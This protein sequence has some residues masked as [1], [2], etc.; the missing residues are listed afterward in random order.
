MKSKLW[1]S[2]SASTLLYAGAAH[3]QSAS[4]PQDEKTA[5]GTVTEV[6]V[7]AE[8]RTVNLQTAAVAASVLSGAELAKKGV[9]SVDQL[10][11][12]MPSVTIQNFGQGNDF[13]IRGIGK[14][15]T[16]SATL[17]GVVTYRDGVATFPGYFQEEPYYDISA[18]EVLRGPQGT[19]AGQNATGGAVF[20]TEKNPVIDGG[21]HGYLQGQYG[22]YNDV[23]VQGAINL[24]IND[25]LAARVAFNDEYRD[26][27]YHVT[28]NYTGH[29][30]ELKESNLRFSLLW[31]PIDALKVLFK[32]DYNYIDQGGFPADPF[33]ATNNPFKITSN[34]EWLAVDQFVRS[35]LDV[36]YKLADGITLRSVTGYQRG[37]SAMKTDL[38][39]TSALPF[40]LTDGD[41]EELW[42]EE[43]N[44]ISPD[45]GPLTWIAGLYYSYD[46]FTFPNPE[47]FDIGEPPRVFDITIAGTNPKET[48]AV[49]GQVSYK[50]ASG[51]E[52]QVGARYSDFSTSNHLVTTI[53]ELGLAVPQNQ[54]EHDSKL[55]GKVALNWTINPNNFV[56]AFVATGH[57]GGGLNASTSL[58]L[59]PTFKPEDVTDYE[60]G[61][62]ATALDGHLKTQLG[63]YYNDYK[64][65]QVSIGDPNNATQSLE[66][67][68]TT[69]SKIYGFEG[70]AQ[71]VFGAL[72]FD[73]GVSVLHSELGTFFAVDPRLPGTGVCSPSRGPVSAVCQNITGNQQDYAPT[74]TLN[75]GAEYEFQLED[76]ATLTP[77]VNFGHIAAQ[78]AT[79]FED[80]AL[81]DRL[82]ERNLLS[83]QLAYQRGDW[84]VIVYG[85]NLTDQTYVSALNAGL[86]YVGPPRQYGLRLSKAF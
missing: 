28:G 15:A 50:L 8:R 2:I 54:S 32:T 80:P 41:N 14:G 67:N 1:L 64:N 31:Q 27:F 52:L 17:V 72:S 26:S 29:P 55:T 3:A 60:V 42:S 68:I 37:R 46:Q 33:N 53:P 19:F 82:G 10:Q 24:P 49:F 7:T 58:V 83:G 16:N 79:L 9:V 40:T 57:K 4:G 36:N 30:G 6:V 61:W 13:N 73:L 21:Y 56:Y 43:V 48:K 77:R 20:I 66:L 70:Q 62:K 12:A 74:F 75:V 84:R 76:G 59:P 86:R 38:D 18:L 45:V 11:T 63:G 44:V 78:W 25:T 23:N 71:A 35:V 47:G 51:L 85:T 5:G 22:N 39:G 65:F 69:P 34:A 81:G